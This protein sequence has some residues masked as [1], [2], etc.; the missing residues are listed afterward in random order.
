MNPEFRRNLILELSVQRMIAMPAILFLLYTAAGLTGAAGVVTW[1]T[2]LVMMG[3][4]VVWG[5]RLAA[6]SVLGEVSA[7]T[8]DGQR[9]SALGPW[10]MCWGKL[11]GSTVFVWYGTAISVP[12]FLYWSGGDVGELASLI[13]LGL[14]SQSIALLASLVF[15]RLRPQR[16]RFQVTLAHLIALGA[17][18]FYWSLMRGDN[19][20]LTWYGG[21]VFDTVFLLLSAIAFLGWA[22]LGIYRLMRGELQFR[23]WPWGWTAFVLFCAVYMAGFSF[24]DITGT[25]FELIA[26]PGVEPILRLL[27]AFA[28]VAALTWAAAYFEPKGFVALRR[29][30]KALF[31]RDVARALEATPMWAPGMLMTVA[32]GALLMMPWLASPDARNV[33]EGVTDID[34]LGAFTIAVLLFL[35]RD[36]GLF[37][38]LTLDGRARRSHVAALVYL[39]VLYALFPLILASLDLGGLLPVLIPS[40]KGSPLV[41]ILPVLLQVGLVAGLLAW[42]WRRVARAMAAGG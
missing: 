8:W 26:A 6:D 29:L 2:K 24:A 9:M 7:R 33:I 30:G 37:Y 38:F 35:S 10:T 14:F 4:S 17:G 34:S 16:M 19:D 21:R 12:V 22:W 20:Y 11:L 23:C 25:S 27:L 28:T 1:V 5:A 36:I 42:R 13:L 3:L 15:L 18:G 40:A 32:A 39:A 41:I 31:E